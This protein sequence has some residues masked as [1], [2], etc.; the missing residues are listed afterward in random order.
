ME[1]SHLTCFCSKCQG[2][3]S[4]VEKTIRIHIAYDLKQSNNGSR[5]THQLFL[6]YHNLNQRKLQEQLGLLSDTA[7]CEEPEVEQHEEH[8]DIQMYP[9]DIY[10]GR[11]SVDEDVNMNDPN[12]AQDLEHTFTTTDSMEGI[13][14]NGQ[15]AIVKSCK[16]SPTGEVINWHKHLHAALFADR[17]TVNSVTGFTLLFTAWRTSRI[18][19]GLCRGEFFS[20]RI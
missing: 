9:E 18:A 20:S 16:K 17:V 15:E 5:S 6:D 8:E 1:P 3:R 12:Q 19:P 14:D 4:R 2:S 7:D 10:S 11:P 13:E